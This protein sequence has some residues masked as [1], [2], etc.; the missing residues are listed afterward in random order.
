MDR[1]YI[2]GHRNPDTDSVTSAVALSYLK[3]SLSDNTV[4]KVLG[5]VNKETK[6]VFDYFDMEVPEKL[7]NVKIQIKDLEFDKIEALPEDRSIFSAY[8]YMNDNRV[9]TLP[10]TGGDG[11]LMG[12]V[13]MKDIA[14]NHIFGEGMVIDTTYDNMLETLGGKAF[15]RAKDIIKG[16][17]TVTAYHTSTIM[18]DSILNEASIVIVGDRYEI[19]SHAVDMDVELIIVTGGRE[20]P[21]EY[22]DKAREKGVNIISTQ[23]NTFKTSKLINLSNKLDSIMKREIVKVYSDSY[24]EDFKELLS[25]SGHSKFPVVDNHKRYMGILSRRHVL[26]P[27]KKKVILVDHNEFEQSAE[28]IHEAEVLEIVDHHKIGSMATT[29]PISFRNEPLGSTNTIIYEMYKEKSIEI[30]DKVA[31]LIMS[32]IISDTLFFKSPTTT[33]KD[34]K[35]AEELAEKL[36][37]DLGEYAY[38]MFKEGTSLKGMTK[39]EIFFSDYKEF[40]HK[41]IK[42]GI[43]QVFTMDIN[44]IKTEEEEEIRMLKEKLGEL[45]VDIAMAVF[46]DI[47]REGSYIISYSRIPGVLKASFS[48]DSPGFFLEGVI[49][50]KKQIVPRIMDG[51]ENTKL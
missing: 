42:F 38:D 36:D 21:P 18:R 1:K 51:I 50:R 30:P 9:R 31:G 43:S 22:L 48:K 4:P 25:S 33:E 10:V 34:R 2:F 14:M 12:I 11:V 28:G 29:Y 16:N 23:N 15:N 26:K 6:Y 3:N 24:L 27:S 20:I 39:D 44:E 17:I 13:T 37:V 19:I 32:G 7:D 35:Y 41:G 49:S 47:I 46:T 45:N 8:N 40:E 5:D